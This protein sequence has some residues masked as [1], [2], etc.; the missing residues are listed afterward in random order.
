LDSAAVW[1]D[2][3]NPDPQWDAY[4]CSS[5]GGALECSLSSTLGIS[6]EAGWNFISSNVAPTDS[7]LDQIFASPSGLTMVKDETGQTYIPSLGVNDI[8]TWSIREGYKVHVESAQEITLS[9]TEVE[10]GTSI[11]LREGWN[12]LP[13][14]SDTTL[15][16][17]EA[18]S[19]IGDAL[20]IVR[21]EEGNTYE[22]GTGTDNI[23]TLVP[24]KSYEV[25]VSAD[26][27][28]AYPANSD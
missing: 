5:N 25:Y 6:L 18:L 9:G 27:T 19:P 28:F 17:V 20:V 7:S 26:V 16:I 1:L 24:G 3:M 22:P 21:D 8:G 13:V 4:K 15:D 23:G 11:D 2:A 10:A 14:H 12:L